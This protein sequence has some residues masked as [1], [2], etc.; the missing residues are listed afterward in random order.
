MDDKLKRFFAP[1]TILR[2]TQNPPN[3]YNKV[4]RCRFCGKGEEETSF[5]MTPHI[6]PELLG[7]NTI[8]CGDECDDCNRLF[9]K[10]ESHLAIY[11]RPYLTMIGV[12]GKK[13]VPNFQSRTENGDESTRTNILF[14]DEGKR[15]ILLTHLNDYRVD[16]K[17]KTMSLTFRLPPCRPLWVY[18][19]LV[20]IGISMMSTDERKYYCEAINWLRNLDSDTVYL[21]IAFVTI[22]PRKKFGSPFAQLLEAD[23]I[24]TGEQFVPKNS[25]LVYFGNIVVQI[26][27][28]L[29]DDFD[30]VRSDKKSPAL[31]IFP[32]SVLNY[33]LDDF[34]GS[35]PNDEITKKYKF[36]SVDLSSEQS[37]AYDQNLNF[38][39]ETGE[40][41]IPSVE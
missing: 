19:A 2:S 17:S 4:K 27:F 9:S 3:E 5:D 37:V 29:P 8:T 39:F 41:N 40:F 1:Y 33:N 22:L 34:V 31:N 10:Y 25:L 28:P 35:N 16:E 15:Q 21:P 26:F 30:F 11:F 24:F 32:A 6:I 23:E 13:G 38:T 12:K 36:T 18:K 20:K 14:T 7:A